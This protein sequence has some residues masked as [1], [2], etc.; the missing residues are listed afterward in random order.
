MRRLLLPLLAL[1][2][3]VAQGTWVARL[4]LPLD[5]PL[6]LTLLVAW[7]WGRSAATALGFWIGA[8]VG[9][10][11]G[12]SIAFASLYALV[13]WSAA[14]LLRMHPHRGVLRAGLL[15]AGAAVSFQGLESLVWRV[16]RHPATMDSGMVLAQLLW[17]GVAF[18]LLVWFGSKLGLSGAGRSETWKDWRPLAYGG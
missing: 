3:V 12:T 14:T 17:N 10:M 13:G 5:M 18:A 6:L 11:T 4:E 16:A 2:V 15:G 1:L 8:L 7:W 9:A